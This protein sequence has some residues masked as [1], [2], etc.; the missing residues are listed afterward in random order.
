MLYILKQNISDCRCIEINGIQ[1]KAIKGQFIPR[2]IIF[3]K[4][5]ESYIWNKLSYIY[6]MYKI[7][8]AHFVHRAPAPRAMHSFAYGE[9]RTSPAWQNWVTC[10]LRLRH[11]T[12]PSGSPL[13]A[14]RPATALIAAGHFNLSSP[15]HILAHLQAH[16]PTQKAN[17]QKSQNFS[18]HTFPIFVSHKRDEKISE[19]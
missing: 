3:L 17:L 16:I 6:E 2:K 1:L 8:F 4:I 18:W 5:S 9:L 14:T 13:A 7:R 15:P 12:S 10:K 11:S 19:I